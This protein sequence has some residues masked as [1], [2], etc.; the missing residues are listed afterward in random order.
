MSKIQKNRLKQKLQSEKWARSFDGKY[1][2]YDEFFAYAT[3]WRHNGYCGL[4][5]DNELGF[6]IVSFPRIDLKVRI[7]V[8]RIRIQFSKKNERRKLRLASEAET[9]KQLVL[10]RIKNAS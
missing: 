5:L 2:F 10:S 1:V 7:P 6:K 8:T 3:L 4:N 9:T